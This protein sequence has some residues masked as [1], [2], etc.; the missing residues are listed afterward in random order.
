MTNSLVNIED[1]QGMLQSLIDSKKLP[2]HVKSVEDA[3][4]IAK[5]GQELGFPVMQALHYV[6]PIQGKLSLSAK[7]LNALLR[8]GGVQFVTVE[9]G[10]YVYKDGSTSADY[11]KDPEEFGKPID[12][13][14]TIKFIR[15]GLEELCSFTWK[16]AENMKLTKKD[17]W[18]RMRKEMLYARCL[19]RGANRIGAD[20]LLGLYTTEE[21]FDHLGDGLTAKRNERG[22]IEEIIGDDTPVQSITIEEDSIDIS[23]TMTNE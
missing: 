2:A 11:M 18:V 4:T 19:S 14:T 6:I 3:F 17:N 20:L 12:I 22:E 13:R 23:N 21:L 8:R 15:D 5:M 16:D 10:V 9:D 1:H 7:A